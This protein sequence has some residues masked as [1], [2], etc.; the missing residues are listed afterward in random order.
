MPYLHWETNSRRHKMAMI[1]AEIE[2]ENHLSKPISKP[3]KK[4]KDRKQFHTALEQ[5]RLRAK[6]KDQTPAKTRCL[7]PY[8]MSIARLYDEMDY[9]ADERLLRDYLHQN[10]PL[11]IRRTLDQS[12]FWT[13]EDTAAKDQDQVVIISWNQGKKKL[14]YPRGHG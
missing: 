3:D 7:G 10:S 14:E 4:E 5:T 9:E 11:H 12:H 2:K 8:L 6:Y 1:V 13:L